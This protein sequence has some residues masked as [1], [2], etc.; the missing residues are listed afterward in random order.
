MKKSLI[1]ILLSIKICFNLFSRTTYPPI[2]GVWYSPTNKEVF[3]IE[4]DDE[5]SIRGRGL[6][7]A[8]IGKNL[9]QMQ[10]MSNMDP[11]RKFIFM[12][13]DP[14]KPKLTLQVEPDST[15]KRLKMTK[16]ATKK[17]IYYF[18]K[19]YARGTNDTIASWKEIENAIYRTTWQEVGKKHTIDNQLTFDD[20]SGDQIPV[21]QSNTK[22]KII[23]FNP[24][25]LDL[26]M[27]LEGYGK[28]R[29]Q[30]VYEK[31]W[32]LKIFNAQN[33]LLTTFEGDY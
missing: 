22:N 6:H 2:E 28:V 11:K 5:G 26:A 1:I 21:Y 24:Q 9:V 17:Q 30:L 20:T 23:A 8:P 29:A 14:K 12:T 13:Y 32:L 4:L 33:K 3:V 31:K 16:F 10:I 19:L 15:G 25:T 7:Y 27:E 18:Y